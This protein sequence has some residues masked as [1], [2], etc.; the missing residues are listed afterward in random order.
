MYKTLG[1]AC[2][3]GGELD[4]VILD[5]E[6]TLNNRPLGYVEDDAQLPILTPNAVML[7]LTNHLPVEDPS[8]MEDVDLRK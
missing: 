8:S 1:K 7:G 2:L 5:I 4:E 3:T 6:T